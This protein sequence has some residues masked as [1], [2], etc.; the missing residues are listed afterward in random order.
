MPVKSDIIRCD[1]EVEGIESDRIIFASRHR[2]EKGVP[3]FT[4]HMPGNWAVAEMGGRN[5]ELCWSDPEL[6]R[7][8]ALSL[9]GNEERKRLG[10]QVYLESDH[11]GPFIETPCVF[12][13]VGSSE[14]EWRDP[15]RAKI[16]AEAIV[17]AVKADGSAAEEVVFGVGGGHYCPAFTKM[18]LGTVDGRAVAHVLPTYHTQDVEYETFL[19]G[20][21]RS[22][23][24]V[25]RI[26]I[27]WKGV[28]KTQ[29]DRIMP[30]I[31]KAGIEWERI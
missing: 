29:R 1:D 21:E 3:A 13:E 4:A 12:I 31:E 17:E 9:Q 23:K 15:S 11:H 7:R 30:F 19:Q 10:T 2:S 25:G 20:V 6:S 16:A 27:D 8:L 5:G 28:N 14:A 26:V 24:K 18:Q 22:T